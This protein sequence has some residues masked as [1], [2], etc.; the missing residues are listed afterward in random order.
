[1]NFIHNQLIA[2]DTNQFIFALRQDP[3]YSSCQILLFE[4]LHKINVYLP[5]QVLIELQC[6]LNENEIRGVMLALSTARNTT[7]DYALA[8][9]HLVQ[10]WEKQGAKKGDAVIA[11]HLET[12]NIPYLIS[13]NRHFL[14]E[15]ADLPFKVLSS[16]KLLTYLN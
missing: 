4:K 10:K 9:S 8:P 13:E 7:W 12:N 11:A 15:I 16:K 2:L 14:H 6:N 5:L 1:M 3:T